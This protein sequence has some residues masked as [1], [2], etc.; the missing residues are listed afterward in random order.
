MTR[1]MNEVDRHISQSTEEDDIFQQGSD[2]TLDD[3][4]IKKEMTQVLYHAM[5]YLGTV[6]MR[7]VKMYFYENMTY[8]EIAEI[9]GCDY[10]PVMKS[11]Q[12]AIRKM[13]KIFEA[14]GYIL[15]IK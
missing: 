7:R 11:I 13:R 14:K 5:E 6:Q 12:S 10:H 2:E 8:E 1:Q 9:E 4:L 15:P 3:A